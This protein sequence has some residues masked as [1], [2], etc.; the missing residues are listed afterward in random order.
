MPGD[1]QIHPDKASDFLAPGSGP[2]WDLYDGSSVA[3]AWY[4]RQAAIPAEWQGRAISLR[5]DRVCTEAMVYV[6]GT[7]CGRVA[8]PWGSVDIT[9]AV[10]PGKTADIRLLV[11]AIADA[12]KVGDFWQNALSSVS[13]RSARL[14]TR[15]LTG[16]VFLESRSSEARV[17]D[18]FVRT[19]TRKKDVSLDV[20]LTGVKQAGPV[21]FVAEMLDEKG[22]VEKSF[23][24]DAAVEA[25][26]TQTV[27]L[28]WPWANP[29]LWDV[30]QP[31]LYTLRLKVK[32]PG[33]DD[34]YNQEFG[35]REFWVE[36]RKFFLNGDRDPPAAGLLLLG[37][38]P[39]GRRQLLGDREVRR[40]MPA[41]MPATRDKTSTTPIARDTWRRSMSST[42]TST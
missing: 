23:T 21:Q 1:W 15:G 33:L 10:T 35:F 24:A 8:W 27:T 38:T 25:K 30:G 16:S 41:A 6:N 7:L 34:E 17:T 11:A 13:Y 22:A 26:E 3:R 39:A 36:G 18:V 28:S 9:R 29:R 19:S 42:P 40:W 4:H 37:S 12:E 20:E 2:Q 14:E 32:G 5:F 31:N